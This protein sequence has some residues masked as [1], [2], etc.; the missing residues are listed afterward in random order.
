MLFR[1]ACDLKLFI[2]GIFPL[3]VFGPWFTAGNTAESK[4]ADKGDYCLLFPFMKIVACEV[5][6]F[7]F[8]SCASQIRRSPRESAQF[9]AGSASGPYRLLVEYQY[10]ILV[11][12]F[13]LTCRAALRELVLLPKDQLQPYQVHLDV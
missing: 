2:S 12:Y 9:P 6:L 11:S 1:K 8:D 13:I 4:T 7:N 10:V 3:D 5:R